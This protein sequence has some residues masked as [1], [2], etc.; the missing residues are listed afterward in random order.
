MKL[1]VDTAS[2][3]AEDIRKVIALLNDVINKQTRP[4]EVA[5]I[6]E[7]ANVLSNLFNIKKDDSSIKILDDEGKELPNNDV[8]EI[9][10]V[11]PY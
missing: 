3:S 6:N 7:Q 4:K 10:E 5:A 11:V 8:E 9:P 2:D 1:T